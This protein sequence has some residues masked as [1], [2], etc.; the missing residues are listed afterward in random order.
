MK[1]R[2]LEITKLDYREE[3]KKQQLTPSGLAQI[4]GEKERFDGV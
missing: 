4:V 1:I 2:K 3:L